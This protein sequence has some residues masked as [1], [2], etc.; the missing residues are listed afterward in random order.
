MQLVVGV[1]ILRDG[2]YLAA[3]RAYPADVAGGW[4]FPGGKVEQGEGPATAAEREIA[5]ELGCRVRVTG[6]LIAAVPI[7]PGLQLRVATAELVAG[8][9]VPRHREHDAVRWLAPAELWSVGWL[10]ADQPF[11]EELVGGTA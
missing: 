6:W 9:P 8:E 4:E 2:R 7:R 1:A 11:V 5:E 10:P 3:R